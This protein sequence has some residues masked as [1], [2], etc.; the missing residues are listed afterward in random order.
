MGIGRV[1]KRSNDEGKE[2]V[3]LSCK[4]R[5]KVQSSP[6]PTRA[7]YTSRLTS[8]ASSSVQEDSRLR[9]HYHLANDQQ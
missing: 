6:S 4:R 5:F 3:T 7:V 2:T 8:T 9:I 1:N